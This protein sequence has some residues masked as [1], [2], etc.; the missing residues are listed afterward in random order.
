[1]IGHDVV[2]TVLEVR[3]DIVRV[4]IKAPRDVDVHREEVYVELQLAN[5][6]AASPSLDTVD[7]LAAVVRS[8]GKTEPEQN[9]GVSSTD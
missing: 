7:S 5:Q 9:E 3:G 6:S 2:V 4:G 1:M 8:G